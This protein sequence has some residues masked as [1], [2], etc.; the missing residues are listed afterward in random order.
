[1]SLSSI[2]LDAFL[3]VAQ[4]ASFSLAAEKLHMTQSAL[5]QRIKNL[6]SEMGLTLFIRH[7]TGVSL[8]EHGERLLRYC[9]TKNSLE[10]EL[11]HDLNLD[12]N[13]E[14]SGNLRIA[15][16]SS[17]FRSVLI[18]SLKPLLEKNTNIL[19]EFVCAHMSELPGMLQRGEV[20]FIIMDY[21]LE[22]AHLQTHVLGQE[23]YILIEPT[24]AS[25]RQDIFLDNA[26][27]DRATELF[28][29]AQ[30]GKAAKFRRSYFD[31][32]YG[33]IDAVAMGLGRAVMP[34]HLVA[35]NKYVKIAKGSK[36]FKLDVVLHY[37]QQSFYSKLHQAVIKNLQD[38][39]PRYL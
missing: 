9:Q 24:K 23:K 20:D 30:S 18:P 29:K 21:L 32:C 27:D 33:I 3:S 39:A 38:N 12:K 14:L 7:P 26:A 19:C 1:M 4:S 31:D 5:S 16:Y 15:T 35:N 6:E 11:I 34:E 36:P 37:H 22:R 17:V 2:Q 28:L 13:H 10:S 8:T 25:D